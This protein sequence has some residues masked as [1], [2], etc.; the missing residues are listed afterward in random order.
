MSLYFDDRS[1]FCTASSPYAYRPA[2]PFDQSPRIHLAVQIEGF[3]TTAFV[4]TGGVFLICPPDVA[5][6]A[7]ID[8]TGGIPATPLL[9]RSNRI[10][11]VLQRVNLTILAQNGENVIIDATAFVPH[12]EQEW[13]QNFPCILGMQ[14]CLERLRFAVDPQTDTFYFG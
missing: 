14:G 13:I 12:P 11:G 8:T 4:D 1:P 10:D 2:S 5:R 7:G 3:E 9:L 6:A